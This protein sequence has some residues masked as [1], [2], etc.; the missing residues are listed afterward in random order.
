MSRIRLT[1]R[2]AARDRFADERTPE[3]PIDL[4]KNRTYRKID[5][6]HTF[7]PK[8]NHWIPDMDHEWKRDQTEREP[9]NHGKLRNEQVFT[10]AKK[11]TK[12]AMMFLGTNA[13]DADIES[14]ARAFMR[15]GDRAMTASIDRWAEAQE[16]CE[17]GKCKKGACDCGKEDCPECNPTNADDEEKVAKKGKKKEEKKEEKEDKDE[18]PA[19]EA[20]KAKGEGEAAPAP[21]EGEGEA[22]PAPAEG[23][24]E[25]AP[26]A[27]GEGD[28][29]F[30]FDIDQPAGADVDFSAP[31]DGE[32]E[33]ADPELEKLFADDGEEE[34]E[35]APEAPAE[36]S[37][38]AGLKK[39]AGQPTLTRVASV[40]SDDLTSLWDK[41]SDPT[42]R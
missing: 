32:S 22:A 9:T 29:D 40:K 25:A 13:S 2:M 37:K 35:K 4:G 14:Q 26:K 19:E 17:D 21:A 7:E 12:L 23:E 33:G 16:E 41:W 28:D 5:Q 6:Y 11:A 42:V 36:P 3:S 15:M 38:K 24:G 34:A 20:P 39:L 31:A 1:Q 30:N 10:A 18:A 27:E 8:K